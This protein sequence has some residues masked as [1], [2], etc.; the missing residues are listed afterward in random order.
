MTTIKNVRKGK[1]IKLKILT[2]FLSAH[3]INNYNRQLQRWGEIQKNPQSKSRNNN[4]CFPWVTAVRVLS[5]TGSHSPP[6]LPR[7]PSNPVLVSGLA[8]GA[9][10]ILF[11][12]YSCVFLP[13][14]SIAIRPSVFSFVVA[15]NNLLYITQIQSLPSWSCG[16][17]LK[18]VQLVKRFLGL[19]P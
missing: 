19:L 13:P 16:F 12:S 18:L 7:M 9:V 10:Q 15:L 8:V 4:K 2:G 17:N 1:K 14:M 5:L 11:W 6:Y 3:K